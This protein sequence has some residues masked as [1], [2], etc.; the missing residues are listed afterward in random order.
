MIIPIPGTLPQTVY[1]HCA[2][3][4][5]YDYLYCLLMDEGLGKLQARW[6]GWQIW[7]VPTWDGTRQGTIWCARPNGR[8]QPV[9]N[10][11][12][13]QHLDDYLHDATRAPEAAADGSADP[14]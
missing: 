8:T 2:S 3:Y 14:S 12:T 13:W 7:A 1:T 11:A 9:I 6:P 10:A 5:V 4:S